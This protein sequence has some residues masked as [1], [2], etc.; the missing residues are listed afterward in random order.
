MP[1]FR[2]AGRKYSKNLAI[3]EDGR[4]LTDRHHSKGGLTAASEEIALSSVGE[5]PFSKGAI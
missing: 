1:S 2:K 3:F 5:D 4:H